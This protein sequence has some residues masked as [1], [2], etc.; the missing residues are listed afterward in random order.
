[1]ASV[2]LARVWRT[3]MNDIDSWHFSKDIKAAEVEIDVEEQQGSS[4]FYLS[5][6]PSLRQAPRAQPNLLCAILRPRHRTLSAMITSDFLIQTHLAHKSRFKENKEMN[7]QDGSAGKWPP[8]TPRT[9]VYPL[10]RREIPHHPWIH[11]VAGEIDSHKFPSGQHHGRHTPIHAN[12][13]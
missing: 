3:N 4:D 13:K 8:L 9:W 10:C 2:Q 7:W 1:M 5:L 12:I 6:M 11:M